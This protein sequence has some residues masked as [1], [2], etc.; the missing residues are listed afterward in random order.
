MCCIHANS[1][2]E[3]VTKMCTL[4]LL[5]GE[6]VGKRGCVWDTQR[7]KAIGAR[8]ALYVRLSQD[9]LGT[10]LGVTRQLE[11]TR[12]YANCRAGPSSPS[13]ATTTCQL[14]AA[15]TARATRT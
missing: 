11:D 1:A 15:N 12:R 4:P 2:R 9:R 7:L 8:A 3:A 5:A 13:T 6:N 14:R 10:E